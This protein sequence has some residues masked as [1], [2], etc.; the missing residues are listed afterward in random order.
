MKKYKILFILLISHLLILSSCQWGLEEL[1]SNTECEIIDFNFEKREII[2]EER[3][4]NDADGNE[5]YYTVDRVVFTPDQK[6]NISIDNED[7]TVQVTVKP[8]VNISNIVGYAVISPGAVIEPIEGAPTLGVLGN[9]SAPKKYR[10]TA[11]DGI[12]SKIWEVTVTQ[13]QGS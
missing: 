12:N 6:A 3:V 1:E 2:Q 9:F 11:A 13:S 10:V 7:N 4:V 5:I 8:E